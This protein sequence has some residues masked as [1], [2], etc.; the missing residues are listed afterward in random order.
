[1]PSLKKLHLDL[2]A[3][4]VKEL[5]KR[6]KS[7]SA[8]AADLG[9]ARQLLRDNGIDVSSVEKSAPLK[10]LAASLPFEETG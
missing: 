7:G 3:A 2:H 8:T 5:L 1:M 6:V 4:T 9:V 10:E